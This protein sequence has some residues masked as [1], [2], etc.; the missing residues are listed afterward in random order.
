MRAA[1]EGERG[2]GQSFRNNVA[3]AFA[4]QGVLET[5]RL[6]NTPRIEYCFS[7][8]VVPGKLCPQPLMT[9]M[10][11]P[12]LIRMFFIRIVGRRSSVGHGPAIEGISTDT[13]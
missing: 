8:T 11:S 1:G 3:T 10:V 6:E 2:Q 9:T 5:L 7:T 4:T 12:S 13:W